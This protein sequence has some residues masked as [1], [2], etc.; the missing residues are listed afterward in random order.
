MTPQSHNAVAVVVVG[1]LL[2]GG[3]L[4]LWMAHETDA[5]T[6]D[7][8]SAV[9]ADAQVV[10]L[11]EMATIRR[12]SYESLFAGSNVPSVMPGAQTECGRNLTRRVETLALWAPAEPGASFGIAARAPVSEEAVWSCARSTIVARGGRPTSRAVE[13]FRVITDE[14]LGPGSAQIAVREPG[15]LLLGR[16]AT[17]SR[18]MD[19][20]AGRTASV[21]AGDH[22][23]MR[24][25]LGRSADLMVTVI[26]SEGLRSRVSR[27]LG[28]PLPLLSAVPLLGAAADLRSTTHLRVIVWC[29]SAHAC[30]ELA[31]RLRAKRERVLG[32]LAMR[33]V[34]LAAL[35]ED[36]QV[37][38]QGSQLSV[39]LSA[40]AH[41]VLSLIDRLG[42]LREALEREPAPRL[43]RPPAS[44]PD[45]IVRPDPAPAGST[46]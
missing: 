37:E 42:A 44:V 17:R 9:P 12:S 30:R 39:R 28:E 27:W 32:S 33:A 2:I 20:L 36:A 26:V 15:L 21:G 43:P 8:V 6:A 40:P 10:M 25:A 7:V 3:A 29:D 18:M 22:A 24:E 13:G 14:A 35:L 1:I 19:A 16:P 45:E 23:R 11:A 5:P 41:R 46:P 38:Q 4:A 31:G 34:G